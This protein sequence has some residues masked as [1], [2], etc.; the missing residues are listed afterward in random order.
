MD[1]VCFKVVYPVHHQM[2]WLQ[3]DEAVQDHHE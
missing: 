2:R 3:S 1:N